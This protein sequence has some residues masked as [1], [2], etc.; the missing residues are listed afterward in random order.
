MVDGPQFR[1]LRKSGALRSAHTRIHVEPGTWG[2]IGFLRVTC[3]FLLF[4]CGEKLRL[5]LATCC[6]KF[7]WLKW[8]QLYRVHR[9]C[10]LSPPYLQGVHQLTPLHVPGTCP[11]IGADLL[12]Y[13]AVWLIYYYLH[14]YVLRNHFM[15]VEFCSTLA[16]GNTRHGYCDRKEWP[17]P[18]LWFKYIGKSMLKK[19]LHEAALM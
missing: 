4:C 12:L 13:D 3:P 11:P 15:G 8:P 14:Q 1:S 17:K 16:K 5:V 6:T 7:S 18:F 2:R 9:S 10:K 19:I